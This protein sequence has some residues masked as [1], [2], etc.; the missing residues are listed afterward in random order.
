MPTKELTNRKKAVILT[1]TV[2]HFCVNAAI[3]ISIK[4][5]FFL[6]IVN[7]ERPRNIEF[8]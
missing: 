7:K 3:K 5:T 1:I 2:E 6:D 8:L 4:T